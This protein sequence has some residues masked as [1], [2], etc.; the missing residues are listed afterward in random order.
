MIPDRTLVWTEKG[1]THI[2][3]ISP[4]DKVISYN[5]A[6]NCM[7]YDVISAIET[8]WYE[9]GLLGIKSVGLNCLYTPDHPILM[10]DLVTRELSRVVI[11]DMYLK[12]TKKNEGLLTPK[13]FEP[14]CRKQEDD[15]L[16][17]TARMAATSARHKRPPLFNNEIWDCLKDIN[18]EEA[19]I[20]LNTF[21]HWNILQSK[22]HY[23]KTIFMHNPFVLDM[24]YHTAPRAGVST[25]WGP[26]KTRK[27]IYM[28]AL[29]IC[30]EKDITIY[31]RARWR[32]DRQNGTI[33]NIST[34]NGNFLGKYL[35][36]TLLSACNYT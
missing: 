14:Y 1:Y 26:H 22:P 24:V 7:E 30:L 8:D 9:G 13:P 10:T 6:R 15:K 21:F 35:G 23:M 31:N 4:G 25:Y 28:S 34:R 11:D 16:Q 3:Y 20:W 19:Q 32:A 5:P 36:G 12:K 29:S 17:W 2:N 27:G 18:A 33:Y